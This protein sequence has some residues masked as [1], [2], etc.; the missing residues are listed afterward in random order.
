MTIKYWIGD[1]YIDVSRNSVSHPDKCEILAP[2]AMAVLTYLAKNQSIV[3]SQDEL[4]TNVWTDTVVSPN[5]LQRSI[6]QI[7]KALNDDSRNS[8]FIATHARRG[9]SLDVDVK[10]DNGEAIKQKAN[11]KTGSSVQKQIPP[12]KVPIL[13]LV[14]LAIVLVFIYFSPSTSPQVDFLSYAPITSSDEKEFNPSYSRDGKFILFHRHAS[15]CENNIWAKDVVTKQEYRLTSGWGRYSS[16]Q[17]S[18]DGKQLVFISREQC[19]LQVEQAYCQNLMSLNFDAALNSPQTPNILLQCKSSPISSPYWLKNE[20]ISFLQRISN[21][22][23][24]VSF[25]AETQRTRDLFV[26]ERG[27]I[28]NYS[29]SAKLD[30]FAL[31]IINGDNQPQLI[32]LNATGEPVSSNAIDRPDAIN[33][34]L[35]IYPVFDDVNKRL[36][37]TTGRSIYALS[38]NGNISKITSPVSDQIWRPSYH[39]FKNS[40]LAIN[41]VFDTDIAEISFSPEE[42]RAVDA[43]FVQPAQPHKSVARSIYMESQGKY[44][45]NGKHI[46]FVSRQTGTQQIWL[47]EEQRQTQLTHYA[48][49]TSIEGIAWSPDGKQIAANINNELIRIGVDGKQS[50]LPLTLPLINIYQWPNQ[51]TLVLSVLI[52]GRSATIEYNVKH[53]RYKV[54]LAQDIQWASLSSDDELIY[55][56]ENKK[57]WRSGQA[58]PTLIKALIQELD[59]AKLVLKNDVIYGINSQNKLWSYDLKN[60]TVNY[61]RDVHPHVTFLTDIGNDRAL[62]KQKIATKKEVIEFTGDVR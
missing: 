31:A 7:R 15:S 54:L 18:P 23:K 46:A 34:S 39:P 32:V 42:D 2:K 24:L 11:Q 51:D 20:D 16:H 37:F 60:N 4:L 56:D 14:T 27:D 49:D 6:T 55:I 25:S 47:S 43:S 59:S 12:L 22:W 28:I 48:F 33:G 50:K 45:P 10:W 57:L 44:Q 61:I 1:Y 8:K 35:N 19:G 5:T 38:L 13:V 36:V 62:V 29:Y 9:Y 3:V 41:G 58:E 26:P 52:A 17:F 21:R 30:L 40:M 53:N